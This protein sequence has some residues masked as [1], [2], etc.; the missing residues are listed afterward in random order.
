MVVCRFN[1]NSWQGFCSD[2]HPAWP[3]GPRSLC[4]TKLPLCCVSPGTEW[5]FVLLTDK[6]SANILL[7]HKHRHTARGVANDVTSKLTDWHTLWEWMPRWA[8]LLSKLG[9]VTSA[10]TYHP[11][12][13]PLLL[14]NQSGRPLPSMIVVILWDWMSSRSVSEWYILAFY[15]PLQKACR[16][17]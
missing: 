2:F 13:K 3:P 10:H 14:Q 16:T 15:G 12:F 9:L 6:A 8:Y 11:H 7:T 4:C 17:D 5:L 1:V